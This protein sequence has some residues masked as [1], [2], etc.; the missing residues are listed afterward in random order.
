MAVISDGVGC[1]K[2]AHHV[3]KIQKSVELIWKYVT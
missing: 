1:E 3:K 2:K